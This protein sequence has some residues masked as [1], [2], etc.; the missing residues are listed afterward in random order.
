MKKINWKNKKT[1]TPEEDW[2]KFKMIH[3]GENRTEHWIKQYGLVLEKYPCMRIYGWHKAIKWYCEYH[4]IEYERPHFQ[5]DLYLVCSIYIVCFEIEHTSRWSK[6]KQH[7]MMRWY[8]EM[9]A[10]EETLFYIYR[11]DGYGNY[12]N[13]IFPNAEEQLEKINDCPV[14]HREWFKGVA[15][16]NLYM[17]QETLLDLKQ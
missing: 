2:E 10:Q 11:F 1:S 16:H 5:P 15:L 7:H 3:T 4:G 17:E 6:D 12:Q 14:E 8:M 9:D 13:V